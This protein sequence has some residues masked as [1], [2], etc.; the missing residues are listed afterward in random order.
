MV[1]NMTEQ[2]VIAFMIKSIN[3]TNRLLAE[4]SGMSPEQ[5]DQLIEQSKQG[6]GLITA[7]LHAKMKEANLLA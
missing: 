3:E 6:I 1:K 4:Q 7:S 5:T 2:E